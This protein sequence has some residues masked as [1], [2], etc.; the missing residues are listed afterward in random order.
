M[1]PSVELF[2]SEVRSHNEEF[3]KHVLTAACEQVHFWSTAALVW[4]HLRRTGEERTVF[5]LRKKWPNVRKS[6]SMR[7]ASRSL[8]NI[9]ALV[10]LCCTV[11]ES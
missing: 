9:M 7:L 8:S 11:S 10:W 3:L 6:Q 4:R 1:N 2:R 5:E